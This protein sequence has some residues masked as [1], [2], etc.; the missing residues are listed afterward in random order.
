M[1]IPE[2]EVLQIENLTNLTETNLYMKLLDQESYQSYRVPLG[3]PINPGS[4]TVYL[5]SDTD[6]K[7]VMTVFQDGRIHINEV[8]YRLEY[9]T[10]GQDASLVLVQK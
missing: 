8:L 9:R 3:V 2:G 5:A 6:K 1:K 10:I 7:A 4:L